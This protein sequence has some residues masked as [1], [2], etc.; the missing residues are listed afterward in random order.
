MCACGCH[1]S[2]T[3]LQSL[4]EGQPSSVSKNDGGSFLMVKLTKLMFCVG[5]GSCWTE[6]CIRTEIFREGDG[7]VERQY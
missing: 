4:Q 5:S 6:C 2:E 1:I 3:V 7:K